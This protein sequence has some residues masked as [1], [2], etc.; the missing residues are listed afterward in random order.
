[1]GRVAAEKRADLPR[2]VVNEHLW[3]V[4]LEAVQSRDRDLAGL[5]L[6]EV[7]VRDHV[8]VC[9]REVHG[10]DRRPGFRQS[11]RTPLLTDHA[12]ALLAL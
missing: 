8:R 2:Q 1:M 11:A 5:N 3:G 6:R 4:C 10:D 12:A 7:K 9:I